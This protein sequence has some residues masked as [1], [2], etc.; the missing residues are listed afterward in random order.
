MIAGLRIFELKKSRQIF[1]CNNQSNPEPH[2]KD[3]ISPFVPDKISS[4]DIMKLTAAENI[5]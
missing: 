3:K 1:L 2:N 5:T 4:E